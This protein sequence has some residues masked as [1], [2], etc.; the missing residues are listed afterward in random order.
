MGRQGKGSHLALRQGA[1]PERLRKDRR[2]AA[3]ECKHDQDRGV[4]GL[5]DE[6]FSR[7]KE[8]VT[9]RFARQQ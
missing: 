1:H 6:G 4:N 7:Q 2:H 5:P 8:Q 3:E 9:V